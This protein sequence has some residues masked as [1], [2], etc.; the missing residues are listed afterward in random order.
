M[1]VKIKHVVSRLQDEFPEYALDIRKIYEFYWKGVKE[2]MRN[3]THIVLYINKLGN[4]CLNKSKIGMLEGM[5][6]SYPKV[7]KDYDEKIERI[8]KLINDRYE[9]K[10]YK[11]QIRKEY[12]E[13]QMENS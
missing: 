13:K 6:K 12:L 9:K 1:E 11:R 4:F 2:D 7:Y 8:K 3:L 10:N 5:I